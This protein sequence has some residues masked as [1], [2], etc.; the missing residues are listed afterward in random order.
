MKLAFKTK[1]YLAVFASLIFIISLQNCERDDIC[2]ETTAT[3][4]RLSVEFYDA[5][6]LE[7]LKEVPRLT[8]YGEGLVVDENGEDID[9][10]ESSEAT[11]VF[12]TNVNS[13]LLPLQVAIDDESFVT[14]RYVLEK[15]TNLRLDDSDEDDSNKDIIE[16]TYQTEFVYVSR[17]CGY[18][19]IFKNLLATLITDEN[20]WISSVEVVDGIEA[21]IENEATVHVRINH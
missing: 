1:Y 2:A 14:T 17:A 13:A 5:T 16:I 15:D 11:I 4:P 6:E 10:T 7:D 8:L 19:S 3:T 20:N 9:P 18:K 21:I 12:N